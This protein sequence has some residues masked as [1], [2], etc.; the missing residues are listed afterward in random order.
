MALGTL[1]HHFDHL[2]NLGIFNVFVPPATAAAKRLAVAAAPFF[3]ASLEP[4]DLKMEQKHI[5]AMHC[6]IAFKTTT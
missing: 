3:F 6:C 2:G 4:P 5:Y 1:S